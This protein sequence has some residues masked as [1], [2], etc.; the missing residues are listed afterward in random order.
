MARTL[1]ELVS[2]IPD[3]S[4]RDEV[5]KLAQQLHD[6]GRNARMSDPSDE[7]RRLADKTLEQIRWQFRAARYAIP[8]SEEL[9][10]MVDE[11]FR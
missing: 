2:A 7:R 3:Q 4:G 5:L 9:Q 6:V 8:S 11:H 10:R 1:S